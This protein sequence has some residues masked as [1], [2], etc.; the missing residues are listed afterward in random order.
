MRIFQALISCVIAAL[1]TACVSEQSALQL[2][3]L[4]SAAPKNVIFILTD[5]HRFDF[6]G[7]TDK[8]AWLETPNLDRLASEGAY[9]PNTYVT[10]SLC[11]PS[12]AS[13]LTGLYSH[14][15]TV[16]DN[17]AP[18][19][20]NLT[21][22]PEY[23]QNSGYQT[24]YFGK[25]HM[26]NHSDDPQPG[27]DHWESFRG[28]GV[29]YGPTLNINGERTTYD[30]ATY[31][32]DVLTEHAVEWLDNREQDQ[33]FFMYLSHKAVHS[34]F[35][36]AKRHE[37]LYE[38]ETIVY[39]PSFDVP[40]YGIPEL[41]TRGTDSEPLRGRDYYGD[42]RI[43]DWVKHQ[44]ESWHGVD[45]MYHG[46]INFKDFFQRYTETLMGIDDSVGEVLDYLD[47]NGLAEDT[48]V[49]YMGDNGFSFGEHG[50]IDKRHFYEESAKVP[51]IVRWPS[52]LRGGTP[53]EALV[54]NIDIAPTIL[55]AAG[56][57][58]PPHMQGSSF[59]P[60]LTREDIPWRDRI[61]YEYYWEMDFPQTPTMFGI[62]T[63]RFK[64]IRYHGIWDTNEFYDLEA[65]PNEMQNLIDAPEHQE[66]ITEYA[67]EVFEWLETTGG[68]NIPLKNVVRP[69]FGD[70]RNRSVL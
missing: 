65:D 23:L 50:L 2:K 44:R 67:N 48:L 10:T 55:E 53:I 54:Q 20:G 18:D 8:V 56:L 6:M 26:G 62:R 19:P 45:Y 37:G 60:L 29:Y 25:W 13:I 21:F 70:H 27:F 39:P 42:R 31:I 5:D 12:R 35:E 64:Y 1:L 3:P 68:M 30:E 63:E 28:Q 51:L 34:Q 47:A 32:T 22:F 61:F 9:F 41:P 16:I 52:Q 15:H 38:D 14:T 40:S 57:K 49:I 66:R 33:P 46:D 17:A 58:S 69:K 36:P 7:F 43:P 4:A 11:S 59:A 24:S